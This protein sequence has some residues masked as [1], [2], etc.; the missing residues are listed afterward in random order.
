MRRTSRGGVALDGHPRD[1][2]AGFRARKLLHM[3]DELHKRV[4]G[5]SRPSPPFPT[6][7]AVRAPG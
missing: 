4:I 1:A 5:R 7:C 6:P 3:E 2:H